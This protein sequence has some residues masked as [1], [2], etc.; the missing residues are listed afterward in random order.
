M[1]DWNGFFYYFIIGATLLLSTLGLW[2][3]AIM[4]GIDSWN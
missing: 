1:S 2:F 3:T 4:P